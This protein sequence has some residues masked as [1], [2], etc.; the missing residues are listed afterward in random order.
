MTLRQNVNIDAVIEGTIQQAYLSERLTLPIAEVV[1]LITQLTEFELGKKML[2]SCGLTS[3]LVDYICHY[4]QSPT[5][6]PL[7]NWLLSR[8][9]RLSAAR[10]RY[11]ITQRLVQTILKSNMTIG[12]MPCNVISKVAELDYSNVKNLTIIGYDRDV[13]GLVHAEKQMEQLVQQGKVNLFLLKQNIWLLDD[14]NQHDLI[15]STRLTVLES[16]DQKIVQLL[17]RLFA[18]LKTGGH[19]IL[20]FFTPSPMV[21]IENSPW[22]GIYADDLLKELCIFKDILDFHPA[23]RTED[24]MKALLHEAGFEALEIYPDKH[25]VYPTIKARKG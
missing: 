17:K 20:S 2:L 10:E 23:A 5:S 25:W 24:N 21:D 13:A 15:L 16:D 8:S 3:P 4:D 14:R 18:A 9:P 6:H 11:N 22:R 1:E 12:V 19:L 7:E